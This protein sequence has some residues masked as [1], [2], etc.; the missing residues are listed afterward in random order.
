MARIGHIYIFFALFLLQLKKISS[1]R[2]EVLNG[3][4]LPRKTLRW[5]EFLHLCLSSVL[6]QAGMQSVA[7][8]PLLPSSTLH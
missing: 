5:E 3:S 8:A 4:V 6:F 1:G 2:G 7:D